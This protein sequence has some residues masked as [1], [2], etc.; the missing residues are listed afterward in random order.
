MNTMNTMNP[1]YPHYPDNI[2]VDVQVNITEP[3][4][5]FADILS[6]ELEVEADTDEIGHTDAGRRFD[7]T[8]KKK[9]IKCRAARDFKFFG[10][11]DT[12]S[13]GMQSICTLCKGEAN[14]KKMNFNVKARLRHHIA[15]RALKQLGSLAPP[16]F[17]KNVEKYLGYRFSVLAKALRVDLKSREGEN[18]KLRDALNEGYHIDHIIPLSSYKII[19]PL[20]QA[21]TPSEELVAH[22]K[23]PLGS[24]QSGGSP[25]ETEMEVDWE[26]FRKCW[27]ISNLSAIP[28]LDNLQ[29][30]A[31]ILVDLVDVEG[32]SCAD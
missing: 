8:K 23:A 27:R 18:R 28:G 10:D 32:V 3:I 22:L 31:K 30:G 13:D 2:E 24:G 26:V 1:H 25:Q 9:C 14:K 5:A 12:S 7:K 29:K 16:E 11:H 17:T 21:G 20:G 19:V 4:G 15:T 6:E